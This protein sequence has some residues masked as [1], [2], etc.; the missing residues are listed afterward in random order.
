MTAPAV[1][2]A[3]LTL[4]VTL[5]ALHFVGDFLLQTHWMASR[6]SKDWDALFLHVLVYA[7][8]LLPFGVVFAVVNFGL[9]FATDAVTSRITARLWAQE[10]WHD[11]FVV[12]GADQLIHFV[13]LAAVLQYVR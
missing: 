3:T 9:H 12:V 10:R 2:L 7:T 11:F 6:K 8:C 1:Y 4:P 13:T 5:L